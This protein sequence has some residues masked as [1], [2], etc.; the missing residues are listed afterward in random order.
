LASYA[1][2]LRRAFDDGDTAVLEGRA[3]RALG[4]DLRSCHVASNGQWPDETIELRCTHARYPNL[5]LVRVLGLFD[6]LG[7]QTPPEHAEAYLLEDID[8]GQLPPAGEAID[9]QLYI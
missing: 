4:R 9:D 3:D 7:R 6:E 2:K 5:E 8:T 1:E